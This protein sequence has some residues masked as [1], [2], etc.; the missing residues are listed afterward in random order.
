MT[1]NMARRRAA[2]QAMIEGRVFPEHGTASTYVNYICR[3]CQPCK[4]A[5]TAFQHDARQRR[6]QD[7][8]DG[9]VHPP[10]GTYSTYIN[11]KCRCDECKAANAARSRRRARELKQA[12]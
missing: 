10:H 9:K 7:M 5:W 2:H 1:A 11:Y 8:L 3:G 6:H 12:A 4:D